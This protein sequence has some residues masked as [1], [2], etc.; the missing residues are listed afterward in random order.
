[1]TLTPSN[2][3]I[4]KEAA[5]SEWHRRRVA[6]FKENFEAVMGQES[7]PRIIEATGLFSSRDLCLAYLNKHT[8]YTSPCFSIFYSGE[9]LA[10]VDRSVL[11]ALLAK[12]QVRDRKT[13]VI[14]LYTL[15]DATKT[16]NWYV[17]EKSLDRLRQGSMILSLSNPDG[18]RGMVFTKFECFLPFLDECFVDSNSETVIYTLDPLVH[19]LFDE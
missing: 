17:L 2:D 3:F 9:T 12:D 16:K 7:L 6:Q 14:S 1:M 4:S 19:E 8:L 11:Q 13:L 18:T 15:L 5:V 10:E